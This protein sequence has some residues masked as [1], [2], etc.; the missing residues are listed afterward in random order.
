LHRTEVP[1]KGVYLILFF[2]VLIQVKVLTDFWGTSY[3]PVRRKKNHVIPENRLLIR[4]A[5]NLNFKLHQKKL[6]RYGQKRCELLVVENYDNTQLQYIRFGFCLF[7]LV[8][9]TF[10]SILVC[11]LL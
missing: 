5:L 4:V 2:A 8:N 7:L 3:I 9:K 11:G 10:Q 1:K 6:V